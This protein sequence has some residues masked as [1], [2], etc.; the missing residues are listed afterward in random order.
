MTR[1][2]AIEAIKCNWPDSRYTILREALDMAISALRE[3]DA[4]DKDVGNNEPLTLDELR[5]AYKFGC[6]VWLVGMEDG[7][8][9]VFIHHVDSCSVRYARIGT[10]EEWCFRTKSYGVRVWAYRQKPEEDGNEA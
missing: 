4:A 3:Q 10:S 7:D 9:W 1:E 6:P 2:E 8:G 5:S